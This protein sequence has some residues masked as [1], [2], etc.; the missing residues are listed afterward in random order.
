LFVL[1]DHFFVARLPPQTGNF[2]SGDFGLAIPPGV[3]RSL[4]MPRRLLLLNEFSMP[5]LESSFRSA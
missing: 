4:G 2:G 3:A 1:G 5:A